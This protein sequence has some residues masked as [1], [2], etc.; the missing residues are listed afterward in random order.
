MEENFFK[1]DKTTLFCRLLPDRK[2]ERNFVTAAWKKFSRDRVTFL[3]C[4]SATGEKLPPLVTAEYESPR[5]LR[6]IGH[7]KLRCSYKGFRNALMTASLWSTGLSEL[8]SRMVLQQRH[9]FLFVDNVT[10]HCMNA[11]LLNIRIVFILPNCTSLLQPMDLG[12]IWSFKYMFRRML[13][14]FI[15]DDIDKI[16]V[17]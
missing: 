15:V 14:S 16:G 10:P 7:K 1:A 11:E 9:T 2:I 3:L 13:L 4:C 6:R 8:K 12:V 17:A 5:C